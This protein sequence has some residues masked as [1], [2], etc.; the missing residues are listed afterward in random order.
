MEEYNFNLI[1]KY[2]CLKGHGINNCPKFNYESITNRYK[3]K[4]LENSADILLNI[5]NSKFLYL[6][7]IKDKLQWKE[8]KKELSI[9]KNN[10]LLK[11]KGKEYSSYT[12]FRK[13]MEDVVYEISC[14]ED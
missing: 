2:C 5:F 8:F 4:N 1:C 3:D 13:L 9:F 12:R 6:E 14:F 10:N 7:T 11:G